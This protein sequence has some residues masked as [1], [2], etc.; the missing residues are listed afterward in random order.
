MDCSLPGSS[1]HGI[2]QAR[3]L[4]WVAISFSRRSSQPRD[5]TQV[6]CIVGR[7]FTIWAIREAPKN[8]GRAYTITTHPKKAGVLV[9][10]SEKSD[11]RTKKN[12]RRG[13]VY[14]GKGVV[15]GHITIQ[16]I[17]APNN[18][19]SKSMKEKLKKSQAWTHPKLFSTMLLKHVTKRRRQSSG[20]WW[21]P[22][23]IIQIR[24]FVASVE[25]SCMQKIRVPRGPT[26]ASISHL[27][28]MWSACVLCWLLRLIPP[29]H[30]GEDTNT[31]RARQPSQTR[32]RHGYLT[33]SSACLSVQSCNSGHAFP[34]RRRPVQRTGSDLYVVLTTLA[35]ISMLVCGKSY[36][37]RAGRVILKA[38]F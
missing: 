9:L 16:Y 1:I 4:E 28:K 36:R 37:S 29:A 22:Y 17:Y 5:W 18:R 12:I 26:E 14:K 34:L 27:Q 24:P 23:T 3:I 13:T 10:I 2:F 33:W 20:W 8:K 38:Q 25:F 35:D 15:Q 6:S 31:D 32:P 30:H 7:R 11:F 19:T 21:H